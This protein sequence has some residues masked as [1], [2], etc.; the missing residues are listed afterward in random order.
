MGKTAF[1]MSLI[2]NIA[3]EQHVPTLLF[4]M[5]SNAARCA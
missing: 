1:A 3:V 4:S 5:E 2:N